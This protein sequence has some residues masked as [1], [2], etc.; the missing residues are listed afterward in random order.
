MQTPPCF[1]GGM[2][3][4]RPFSSKHNDAHSGQIVQFQFVQTQDMSPNMKLFVPVHLQT[5]LCV[6]SVSFGVMSSSCRVS[7]FLFLLESCLLP[8]E[9]PFFCV[10]WSH[11]FFLQSVLSVHVLS[12]RFTVDNDTLLQLQQLLL[13]VFFFCSCVDHFRPKL[14]RLWDTCPS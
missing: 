4:L 1:T 10:F 6:F 5:V 2:V 13:Q 8:A 14:V 7:F 9:C 11:V 12:P 3:F